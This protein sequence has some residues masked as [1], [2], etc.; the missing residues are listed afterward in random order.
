MHLSE[1][2]PATPPDTND[3]RH[4]DDHYLPLKNAIPDWLGNASSAR[5]EA[6]KKTQPQLSARLHAAPAAQHVEMKTLSA[7]H[8]AAQNAVD[9]SLEHLQDAS[10][11]AEPLLKEQLKNGFDLDVDVRNTFMRLYIPATT[12]WFPIKT[13]TRAWTISL[14]DAALHNFE[15]KETYENAFE[16]ESTYITRPSSTGQF[17]TLPAIKSKLSIA[18]FTQ[19]CRKLDIG[20]KYK[21]HLENNL[22]YSDSF[23]ATVLRRKMDTSEKAAMKAALQ[24]ARMNRDISESNFRLI[25]ALLEGMKGIYIKGAP[26]LC[27]DMS[28][29]AAPLTGIVVFAADLYVSRTT[30]QVV[31]YVPNDPEHPF[32]EY[33]SAF[34]MVVELTRQLRS[35]D[36]QQFFSRFVNHEQRGYFFS[37]LNSRLSQMKWH[38]HEPGSSLPAWREAE[39]ERPDLQAALTA[40]HDNLWQHLHQAKLNK[41]FNDARV[42]AVPTASVDQKARW[43]FWDSVVNIVSTIVQ[44][45]ALIVAPFVPVLGEAM[46]AYMAYQMLDE[47]FEGI[48][49]WAQGRTTEAFEHLMGTVES[50]V[51]LGTF[52]MGGAIGVG[53]FRKVL[54]KEIVAFIDRFKPVELASGQT[55]YWEPDLARY[56]QKSLPDANSTPNELGLHEHQGK[57]L[58]P[59]EDAHF[60]VTESDIPGQ[61]RIEH[62]TRPNAYQPRVRHNSNGAWHTELE[63][64]LEWNKPTALRRIGPSVESF[65]DAERETILEVSGFSEDAVRKMHVEQQTL[66]P[67]LADS[68]Q[69]FKIDQQ[70]RQFIDQLDSDVSEEYLRADPVTQLQLLTEQGRWSSGKRLRLVDQQGELVWQSSSDET[71]PLTEI[72]QDSL[73]DGDLLKTLLCSL[74]ESQTKALL[75]EQFGGPTPALDTRT[76]TLRKQLALLAR[77]HRS[78]LFES[79]YQ[80]LQRIDDPLAQKLAQHNPDLP[81]S[82]TRELL[83]TATGGE[84][85]QISEGQLPPRQQELMQ[86]AQQEVRVT[87]AYEGLQID[88][89]SNPDSDT[90]ALHSLRHLPGWSGDVRIEMLD[91]RYEGPVLSSIGSEDAPARKVL[92]R[93]SDGRYQPYD[94][95]GQELHSVTDFYTSLLYALPDGERRNLNIQIGQGDALKAAIRERTLERSE[96]REVL[97]DSP[98]QPPVVDTLRLLGTD[99]Y[100]HRPPA[101]HTLVQDIRALYPTISDQEMHLMAQRI[102]S[103]PLGSRAEILRLQTEYLQLQNDLQ[104]WAN[105]L[106][107]THPAT[108]APLTA[109]EKTVEI[110]NR[111][112]LREELLRG[113]RRENADPGTQLG[114]ASGHTVRLAQPFLGDLP[115]LS[116]DFSHITTLSIN[117]N[118]STAGLD[119]FLR[120]FTRLMYLDA[121]NLSLPNLPQAISSMPGLRHLILRNCGIG[122]DTAIQPVLASLSDLTLLDLQG[123]A[124]GVAPDLHAMPSLRHVNLA[125]TRIA[126]LPANVLDHPN[127]ITGRFDGN[128]IKHVP[129]EFFHLASSLSDGYT[130]ANNPLSS[131]SREQVKTFFNHTGK[132]FGA[133]PEAADL[134]RTTA[135]FPSLD[136]EQASALLYRLPGTLGAGRAQLA[137]WEAEI[138]QLNVELGQW[139]S[140]APTLDPV[141][142]EPLTIN[143]QARE[144]NARTAFAQN[145]DYFWRSR[146]AFTRNS[147]LEATLEFMGDMPVLSA[148]FDHVSKLTLTGNPK[149]SVMAPFVQ[150]FPNLTSLQLHA[151]ELEPVAL[152]AIN[153][154]WLTELELKS[155]GVMLTS[156]N[157]ATL[158]SFNGLRTL[159]LSNNPLGTF[160]DLNLLPELTY[161]DLSNCGLTVVPTGLNTHPKL[162][163][164]ILSDNSIKEIPDIVFYMPA[165]RTD[166]F[167]FSDNKLSSATRDKIKIYYRTNQQ[168]FD[169]R[170]DPA[171]IALA[172]ELFPS[173][174]QQEASDM[175]Y[176]LPGTLAD[177]RAQLDRWEAELT[178]M[179]NDLALWAPRVPSIHPVTG[180]VFTAIELFD[181]Y[182]ARSEFKQHLERFW[183]RRWTESGMRDDEFTSELRFIG[184]M[185][186]LTADFSHV[187]TLR[188]KG[189]ATISDIRSFVELFPSAQT[190]EMNNFALNEIPQFITHLPQL[191]ELTLN[192]CGVTLTSAGQNSLEALSDLELLDLSDNTLQSVP[193]LQ[194]LPAIHDVRLANTGISTLPN[195]IANHPNLRSALLNG[196]N[197]TDLPET[198][199]NLNLDLAD[200]VNLAGN[201]LSPTV[202]DRIK[203][204]YV[205]SGRDFGVQLPASDIARA[206]TLFPWM[207]IDDASHMIYHLPGT[208]EAGSAQLMLWDAEIAQMTS[209]L[210]TWSVDIPVLNPS[211]GQIWRA[212]ERAVEQ[213]SRKQF[214]QVL[215][216]FWRGRRTDKPELRLN[217]LTVDATFTGELPALTADFNHVTHL[218]M[219]GNQAL[220]V[221]DGFLMCFGGLQGLELRGFALGRLPSALTGMPALESLMLSSCGVVFKDTGQPVLSAL[222]RLKT[223]DM[224]NNPL[225]AAPD[226]TSLPALTFLDLT[227]TGID[228][229]PAGLAQLRHLEVALLNENFIAELPDNLAP[230]SGQGVDLDINPLSPAA[231]ERIKAFYQ[232]NDQ[233]LGVRADPADIASAQALYPT[234]SGA[235]ASDLVYRLP[236]TLAQ[237]RLELLRRQTELA[238]LLSE[239]DVWANEVPHDPV[240]QTV[241]DGAALSEEK[242]HRMRF[243]VSVEQR[244]RESPLDRFVTDFD[245]DMSFIGEL[246][247]LSGRF[248]HVRKLTLTSSANTHPRVDRLLELFPNLTTLDIQDYPLNEI[249]AAALRMNT[250][251]DLDLRHCRIMLSEDTVR[252]LGAMQNLRSLNLANNPLGMTPDVTNMR[253]LRS[254]HLHSTGL[255]ELPVGLLELPYLMYADLSD[256]AISELPIR[257][258][259]RPANMTA[260]Y[261]FSGNR[262]S[263]QSQQHLATYNAA[264][265]L[266]LLEERTNRA[267]LYEALDNFEDSD[268]SDGIEDPQ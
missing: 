190:L 120:R 104:I 263:P 172:Q 48:I 251:E 47:A 229:V 128:Q 137:A 105:T 168:D 60:A 198:F 126:T 173:L 216:G 72:R 178:Q 97:S 77:R 82:V 164:V 213:A 31:A 15:E 103:N 101:P 153:L 155:C 123:N 254:L 106:P 87:R 29:L 66:P 129:E 202:R 18:A 262:L 158:L 58:L 76:Q 240:T 255:S 26:V 96:L 62:P 25:D 258:L 74:D 149:I 98:V 52:A 174:D 211:T 64:P 139:V 221:S 79:R 10:N 80:A 144:L 34:E 147:E 134:L 75:A 234:L 224:Y 183:R 50:L 5:R 160:P 135:L 92:V 260:T 204:Y 114:V 159:E 102:G 24:W 57:Q 150:L 166:G 242:A 89:V 165:E 247:P 228:S 180:Q 256:N 261:N 268:F 266:R 267:S 38:P 63:R 253:Q 193:D 146:S 212:T 84:V 81:A 124:L 21:A 11:F 22:G 90:L 9:R 250:L 203:T 44:T 119:N 3:P 196:N 100:P 264:N 161:I 243:K 215:E 217:T 188:L 248:D 27:H 131:V 191:K 170:A 136:T 56:E 252:D 110:Q 175:I 117:G 185:P 94:D 142:G 54:P 20:A 205:E 36:Y 78:T 238:T 30:A 259:S 130:F 73:I 23:V 244:L 265:E 154:P 201:P 39:V 37:T 65:S 199:F 125:D 35:K 179:S 132:H 245:C 4:P 156:E 112:L 43:A 109:L 2:Q 40:F 83:D 206:Q 249:P 85:V 162:R 55:R 67:L 233:N 181:Q 195:G 1:G 95:R 237:G 222:N 17:D 88:S 184:D 169:V 227:R 151:F 177:S 230:F 241:L 152:G 209:D 7:A 157:E 61:Y 28:M 220:N 16:A 226:V 91:G 45:A 42:I 69:R 111:R 33:A 197:I 127:L 207:D 107:V 163:T 148:N 176:D 140:Q 141:S 235:D 214:S 187:S 19:L 239:L 68:I 225:G 71:L 194:N 236:G 218:I 12:P 53:E 219:Q 200:S 189:N 192:H 118:A 145:V 122:F 6:L 49:E 32:K 210:N 108:R 223:L 208:L 51:Q 86:L 93:Q 99:G 246:P 8:M 186:Q 41:I 115:V 138:T 133:H 171:D 121:H 13:G 143:E 113:W 59:L 116:A 231:R 182:A 232:S 70:L 167:D 14:L 46:M 257:L